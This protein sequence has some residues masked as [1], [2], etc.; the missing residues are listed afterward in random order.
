M[1][2]GT[3]V[4]LEGSIILSTGNNSTWARTEPSIF[5]APR[6][7]FYILGTVFPSAD[8]VGGA[9]QGLLPVSEFD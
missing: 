8:E 1:R 7:T 2:S 4:S 3:R 5:L 9:L 6:S